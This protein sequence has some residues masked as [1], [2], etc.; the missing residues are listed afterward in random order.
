MGLPSFSLLSE[1]VYADAV[2][3]DVMINM[4]V[5]SILLVRKTWR[6]GISPHSY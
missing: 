3:L 2:R 4:A 6:N 1:T 5:V